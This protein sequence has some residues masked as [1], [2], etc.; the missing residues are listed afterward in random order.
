MGENNYCVYIHTCQAPGDSYGKVYIG[1]TCRKPEKRWRGGKN[2]G[3]CIYFDNA[4]KKYG[5]DNFSHE[6]LESGLCRSKALQAERKYIKQFRAN[7]PSFGFNLTPGGDRL[8]GGESPKARPVVVFDAAFGVR[9]YDFNSAAEADRELGITS[10]SVLRGECKTAHGYIVKYLDDVG[11]TMIL[12]EQEQFTPR[13]QPEKEKPIN[14]YDDSGKYLSTYRSIQSAAEATGVSADGISNAARFVSKSAGGFQWRLDDGDHSNIS[15]YIPRQEV[16]K[17]HGGY[18][19][20]KIDQIDPQSGKVIK[21]YDS[22]REAARA[23]NGN[24]RNI[25]TVASHKRGKKTAN[26]YRWEYR[27]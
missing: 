20:R 13:A 1:I 10:C 5:W 14:Q 23:V 21:T 18:S 12:S 11:A 4:I 25:S 3:H 6:I 7:D 22:V 8:V 16:R 9:L 26:G 2:Y 24:R 17:S 19:G 15:R 27:E